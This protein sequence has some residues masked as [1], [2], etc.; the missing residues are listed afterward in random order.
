M[1]M[2]ALWQFSTGV[3]PFQ[4]MPALGGAQRMRG[5][6]DWRF[7]DD[8]MVAAQLEYRFPVW[9]RFGAAVFGGVGD[10]AP[11]LDAFELGGLELA[12]GAGVRLALNPKD[13]VNLR[14]DFGAT[15]EGDANLY[16]TL[17]EAF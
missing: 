5:F 1:Q 3:V 16:I 12:G 10:V 14:F 7:R 9:W 2:V 8:H 15:S 6:F 17:G 13:R 4:S 11:E